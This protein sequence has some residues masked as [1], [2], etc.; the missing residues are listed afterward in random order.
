MRLRLAVSLSAVLLSAWAFWTSRAEAQLKPE[1]VPGFQLRTRITSVGGEKPDGKKFTFRF[2]V[3][4]EPVTSTGD[5]WTEWLTFGRPQIEAT[6][7]G[8]PAI[9]M[10]GYPLVT[11]LSVSGV[12]DP[13]LVE[14]EL[15]FDGANDVISM[16]AE[17][18]PA[19]PPGLSRPHQPSHQS[20]TRT[21]CC[22]P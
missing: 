7:R 4:S 12:A 17:L 8:Y 21:H 20:P 13:S 19:A 15:K 18:W 14:A 11:H 1:D 5:A 10:K 9:Y 2:G 16:K 3:P 6:L 22:P